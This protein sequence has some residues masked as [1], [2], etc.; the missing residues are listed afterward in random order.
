MKESVLQVDSIIF[1]G[2]GYVC[3]MYSGKFEISFWHIKKEVNNEV[4]N[5]TAMA[6]SNIAL[7]TY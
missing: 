3:P 4:R 5:K 7:T 6:R 1:D 2:S